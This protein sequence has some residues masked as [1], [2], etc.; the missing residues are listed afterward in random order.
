MKMKSTSLP[1]ELLKNIRNPDPLQGE[2]ILI[3]DADGSL[4]GAILQP[5]AYEFFLKKIEEEE[6]LL[7]ASI[8]EPYDKNSKTL[9]DLLRDEE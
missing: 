6:E 1:D 3:E 8:N 2:D 7:D 9:D 4:I 5:K